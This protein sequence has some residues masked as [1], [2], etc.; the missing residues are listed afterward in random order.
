MYIKGFDKN[1][2]TISKNSPTSKVARWIALV[3]EKSHNIWYN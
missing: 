1:L 2:T 3:I